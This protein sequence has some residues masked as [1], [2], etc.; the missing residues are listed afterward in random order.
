MS[1]LF[2]TPNLSCGLMGVGFACIVVC[3][4]FSGFDVGE[5]LAGASFLSVVGEGLAWLVVSSSFG[6]HKEAQICPIEF[7]LKVPRL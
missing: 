4:R 2:L 6:P 5:A 1:E 7:I 3:N